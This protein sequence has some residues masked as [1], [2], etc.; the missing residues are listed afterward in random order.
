MS[1]LNTLKNQAGEIL[2]NKIL[3]MY[4]QKVLTQGS[5]PQ[6][7]NVPNQNISIYT[8]WKYGNAKINI[9]INDKFKVIIFG[10]SRGGILFEPCLTFYGAF[11]MYIGENGK[12]TP[13]IIE[14]KF[15]QQ[16]ID[17]L[18][19]IFEPLYQKSL[20]VEKQKIAE[21]E[22]KK[23]SAIENGKNAVYDFLKIKVAHNSSI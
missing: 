9:V 6:E 2:F 22:D 8:Y 12:E 10:H 19:L 13:I 7:I 11:F 18:N 14:E 17:K 1:K 20:P 3:Y 4:K 5:N 16:V 21:D 23:R 15:Y